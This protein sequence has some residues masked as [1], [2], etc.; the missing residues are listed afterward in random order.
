MH[1]KDFLDVDAVAL[2]PRSASKKRVLADVCDLGKSLYQ[3]TP[4]ELLHALLERETLGSTGVGK[5]VAIPHARLEG[6]DRVYGFFTRLNNPVDFEAIDRQPVDLIFTIL[7]P[8]SEG[9]DHLKALAAVSRTLR[10]ESICTK[11][12]ASEDMKTLHSI[13]TYQTETNA[14]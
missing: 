10:S 11:L 5:G 2:T 1:I 4:E 8:K 9:A 7:A 3:L 6:L 13:L 12:R 14:A